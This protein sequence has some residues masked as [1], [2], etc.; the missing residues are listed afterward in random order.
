MRKQIGTTL[1]LA[2]AL[3]LAVSVNAQEKKPA[4]EP[5]PGIKVEDVKMPEGQRGVAQL[6]TATA[7]V[8]AVNQA[9]RAVTL[10]TPAGKPLSFTAGPEVKNLAQVKVG[11]SVVV[12]YYESLAFSLQKP[13]ADKALVTAEEKTD[14][15]KAGQKPSASEAVKVRVTTT[16]Q[17]IDTVGSYVTLV[18]PKGNA[19]DVKVRD[20]KVFS[21]IKVGDKVD[22]TYTEA[23]AISV[24]PAPK[25]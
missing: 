15:A 8:E 25:K 13:G 20:P 5:G 1:A 16:I 2:A 11:D 9:T 12:K 10:K 3:A 19:Y 18:G 14:Q 17:A 7:T 24:E 6:V 4:V 21:G 22:V 23:L